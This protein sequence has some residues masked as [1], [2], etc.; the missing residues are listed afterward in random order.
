MPR[1]TSKG[2]VIYAD[3]K[4]GT[5]FRLSPMY[6]RPSRYLEIELIK[7]LNAMIKAD[8]ISIDIKFP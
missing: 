5:S 2:M 1:T 8:D 3:C 6:V 4:D 7:P